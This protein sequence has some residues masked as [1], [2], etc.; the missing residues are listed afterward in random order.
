MLPTVAVVAVLLSRW[1]ARQWREA[2]L[3]GGFSPAA[4]A[5][6]ISAIESRISQAVSVGTAAAADAGR[7]R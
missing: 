5:P 4:A 3:A 2:F 6:F 7:S 1:S